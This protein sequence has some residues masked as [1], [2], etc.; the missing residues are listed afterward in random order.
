MY[1]LLRRVDLNLVPI[2]TD[3]VALEGQVINSQTGKLVTGAHV[4]II[5]MDAEIRKS[6]KTDTN[7]YFLVGGLVPG[8]Y[9][10]VVIAQNF[11]DYESDKEQHVQVRISNWVNPSPIPLE[12]R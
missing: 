11:K 2:V 8:R 7:G 4:L 10:V 1:Q 9:K 12:P 6:T 5:H 3:V